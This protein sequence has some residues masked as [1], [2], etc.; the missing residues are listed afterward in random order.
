MAMM[1]GNHGGPAA[2][3]NVTPLIDVLLVLIIIFMVITP[4]MPNG[5]AA[6]VPQQ[7]NT[8]PTETTVE[9][10]TVVVQIID[11]NG[12]PVLKINQ[13][14][15]AWEN[16]EVRLIDIFKTRA[17]RVIFVRADDSV[18]FAEVARIIDTA[19]AAGISRIGLMTDKVA[20]GA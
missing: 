14:D 3:M 16:L 4:L 5:L 19:H 15:V 6:L 17:E 1:T 11:A 18:D 10:R 7:S 2:E 9:P 20:G 13:E 12:T 8:P